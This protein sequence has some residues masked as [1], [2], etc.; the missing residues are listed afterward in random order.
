MIKRITVLLFALSIA[1]AILFFSGCSPGNRGSIAVYD[2]GGNEIANLNVVSRRNFSLAEEENRAY[3]ETVVSEA[4]G[5]IADLKN[6]S[7]EKARRH[8][9][10]SSY[11]IYTAFDPAVYTAIKTG[12]Q[13]LQ[14]GELSF[15][16]AITDL[17]GNLLATYSA[18][19]T[20]AEYVNYA[21]AQTPPYSSFKPLCVYAPAIEN[22]QANW[23][24]LFLDAPIKTIRGTD[25]KS[26]DWPVNATRTY[27]YTGESLA[28]A[29]QVSLNTAAVRCMQTVGV[30]NSFGF[31]E[32]KFDLTLTYEKEKAA[33]LGADEV[34]GN[35]ALGYL[36]EGVSPIQMAGYYQTF[37]NGGKYT[38]PHTILK[39]C[40]EGGNLVYECA[41]EEKQVVKPSTAYIMNRLLQNVV[42]PGGTGGDAACEGITVGGKTGTGDHGNWFVGFTP[43]YTCAV[44][45]GTEVKKNNACNI[46][47]SI[48]GNLDNTRKTSFPNCAGIKKA[49]YCTESGMLY[50]RNCQKADVGYYIS[51]T[52]P[53]VCDKH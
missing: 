4:E 25:G 19:G 28:H 35:V 32:D 17:H 3:L 40:D 22:S 1:M 29:I 34:I 39:I 41:A 38:K 6:L 51:D 36:Y 12:Y 46:F 20:D 14:F 52:L 48:M 9:L 45:H 44:W 5:V 11:S 23:S 8:L 2:A 27:S 10:R 33:A 47:A 13:N 15:G 42:T 7:P 53:Q 31:L 18:K 30:E 49:A 21:A 43:Q 26:S 16:C 24:T 37:A 50:S